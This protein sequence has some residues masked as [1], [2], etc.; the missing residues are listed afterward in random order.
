VG[1]HPHAPYHGDG[2]Q[3][4]ANGHVSQEHQ[5]GQAGATARSG[6]D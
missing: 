6:D 2:T 4:P 1:T 5:H 3:H